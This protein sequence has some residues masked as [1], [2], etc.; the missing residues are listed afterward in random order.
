[1]LMI[2]PGGMRR[3]RNVEET[4]EALGK[5]RLALPLKNW[6]HRSQGKRLQ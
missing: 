6:I 1:M 3:E 5:K 4:A 2:G